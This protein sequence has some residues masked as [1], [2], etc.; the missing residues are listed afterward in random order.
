MARTSKQ[1]KASPNELDR[2]ATEEYAAH[3]HRP[4]PGGFETVDPF[5]V[6]LDL[7]EPRR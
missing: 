1:S 7:G 6:R 3:R 4:G 2:D 5:P